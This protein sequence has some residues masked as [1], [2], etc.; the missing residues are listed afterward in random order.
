MSL[1]DGAVLILTHSADHFTV[2][3]VQKA[4]ACQGARSFRLDTDRFPAEVRLSGRLGPEDPRHWIEGEAAAIEARSVRAVWFRRVWMPRQDA[5]LDP[6]FREAC[7][8]ESI[9]ALYAVLDGL[10]SVR[11][12]NDPGRNQA[13]SG[14]ARQLRLAREVGLSIP[15]TLI[16][17]DARRARAFYDE[18][19]GDV[20]AKLLTALSQSMEGT[21][22]AVPTSLVRPQ[23]LEDLETLRLCPMVFQERVRKDV[24]LRVMYV[25]GKLFTGSIDARLSAAGAVDWRSAT[26][27]ECRWRRDAVPDEVARSLDD[28]MKALGLATGAIDLIRT[29]SGE[30]VFLEVNPTGEWGMLERDLGLPVSEAIAESLL[31][32]G[33]R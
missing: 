17:N 31:S 22:P 9:A 16:T 1:R 11:W 30:H 6:G 14:K 24:E 2:D 4:L 15:R 5:T 26:P 7:N 27:E 10:S 25:D 12:I 28:L 23:D 13:A 18:M 19:G 21:A 8:R 29:P 33:A 20:V 3:N 32:D